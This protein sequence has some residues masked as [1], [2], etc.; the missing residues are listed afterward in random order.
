M[1]IQFRCPHCQDKVSVS[2]KQAGQEVPCPSCDE[3]IEVPKLKSSPTSQEVE[4]PRTAPVAEDDSGA[5]DIDFEEIFTEETPSTEE[6]DP[7][8]LSPV[9]QST[10]PPVYEEEEEEE[11]GV[12]KVNSDFEELDLTPMVDV[13]FLLLIFFMISASF[14]LQKTMQFPPPEPNEE[15]A[16]HNMQQ[17]EEIEQESIEIEV[18]EENVIIVDGAPV[19]DP[20]LL[21]EVIAEKASASNQQDILLT[22]HEQALHDTVVWVFDSASEAGIQAVRITTTNE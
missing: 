15:G 12:R 13:T 4:P 8:T 1:P 7:D 19:D 17:M 3:T 2:R 9:E 16:T 18:T 14:S 5:D 20:A 6:P 21:P 10:V 11:F 22:A